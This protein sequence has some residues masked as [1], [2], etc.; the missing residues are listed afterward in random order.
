MY[1][2]SYCINNIFEYDD[3][4]EKLFGLE[5]VEGT[6]PETEDD[7]M[8][9]YYMYNYYKKYGYKGI[10]DGVSVQFYP[11]DMKDIIGIEIFGY[12]ITGIVSTKIDYTKYDFDSNE[13]PKDIDAWNR[14]NEDDKNGLISS[15]Y[16][17]SST[18]YKIQDIRVMS[19]VGM[20]S[21]SSE[22]SVPYD[23]ANENYEIYTNKTNYKV[24]VNAEY[25]AESKYGIGYNYALNEFI[26]ENS[27]LTTLEAKERFNNILFEYI[28]SMRKEKVILHTNDNTISLKF[29]LEIDGFY[30]E[31]EK[32]SMKLLFSKDFLDEYDY[33]RVSN[34]R[35]VYT[36]FKASKN[37]LKDIV[38]RKL[39]DVYKNHSYPVYLILDYNVVYD[40]ISSVQYS[41]KVLSYIFSGVSILFIIMSGLMIIKNINNNMKS[42]IKDV[43]ILRSMGIRLVDLYR[44]FNVYNI[45]IFVS[46]L[47][48]SIPIG[49]GF[50]KVLNNLINKYLLDSESASYVTLLINY[51]SNIIV[52]ILLC[53]LL[54]IVVTI[55][56][57][58][59]TTRKSVNTII[60][61]E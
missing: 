45:L 27:E 43:G 35:K 12:K 18:A 25:V 39:Y 50:I 59:M 52:C 15:L 42:T 55:I 61:T 17:K 14:Y 21:T 8:M 6:S 29:E 3:N 41:M 56:P 23:I 33:L 40:Q 28:P 54:P 20:K 7:A 31:D 46:N 47:I 13:T 10:K 60:K 4:S 58:I 49:I 38:D 57:I 44:I 9:T 16:V 36:N 11:N 48:I 30:I 32:D 37:L 51:P 19:S 1:Y 22:S 26:N 5:I 2:N 34:V 53:V 24:L